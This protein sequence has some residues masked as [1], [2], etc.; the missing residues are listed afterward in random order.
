MESSACIQG[1]H[2]FVLQ[3]ITVVTGLEPPY[4]PT[5][6]G[7]FSVSGMLSQDFF[8]IILQFLRFIGEKCRV[9][10]LFNFLPSLF[11]V[12]L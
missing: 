3:V 4:K 7:K 6:K 11:S 9:C 5:L 1:T 8:S 10:A 12:F 2:S